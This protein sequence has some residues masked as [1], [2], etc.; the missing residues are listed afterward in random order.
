ML[1]R[2]AESLF[3]IGRYLERA[4]DTCR[5]LDVHVQQLVDDPTVDVEGSAAALLT[6]IGVDVERLGTTL[7]ERLVLNRLLYDRTAPSSVAHS[8][9][10]ARHAARGVR[11]TLSTEMWEG[12]NTSFLDVTSSGFRRRQ[13]V[14]A[15]KH[16][17]LNCATVAG[18]ADQ[19][20]THDEGWHFLRL[21]LHLE[22]TDMTARMLATAARRRSPMAWQDALRACGAQHAFIRVHGG[23]RPDVAAAEF[24]LLDQLFPRSVVHSL[25][26]VEEALT[27]VATT[28]PGR[29]IVLDTPLRL[30]GRARSELEYRTAEELLDGLADRMDELQ[31]T[32]REVT[33]A[34]YEQYFT[35]DSTGNWHRGSM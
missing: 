25:T 11:E 31:T 32:C 17:R 6:S 16:V 23:S 26:S 29:G 34:V 28:E 5:L 3:W 35:V 4:E 9:T 13:P 30:V 18:I 1:S 19:T 10:A 8:L 7:D 12:I 20:M 24:L 14:S 21:G 22:R 27:A 2:I 15:L 33:A